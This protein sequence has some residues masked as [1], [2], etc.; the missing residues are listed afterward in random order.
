LLG[1]LMP[2]TPLAVVAAPTWWTLSRQPSLEGRATRFLLVWATTVFVC[3]SAARGKLATYIVPMFPPLAALL[4]AF[5]DRVLRGTVKRES[6]APA[7]AA[8]GILLVCA[9]LLVLASSATFARTVGPATGMLVA[10][11][12]L[13]GGIAVFRSRVAPQPG[14]PFVA[15]VIATIVLYGVL[16]HAAASLATTLTAKPL[17]DRVAREANPGAVYALWGKYLPSAAFYLDRPPLLVGVRPELRFGKSLVGESANVV[18][19]L[20]ELGRRTAGRRLYVFT[21]DRSKREQELRAALGDVALVARDYDGALWVRVSS[22]PHH[23]LTQG[24]SK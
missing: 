4:G 3:F 16:A 22:D 9:G 24:S 7:W 11:P 15:V 1:G 17:I 21:D 10:S 2:W 12:L 18:V 8:T 5:L 6:L 14:R 13:A 20:A 19:D 23:V